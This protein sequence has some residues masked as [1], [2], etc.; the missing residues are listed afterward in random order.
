MVCANSGPPNRVSRGQPTDPCKFRAASLNIGSLKRKE[1]EVVETLTRRRIDICSIQEHRI[2]GGTEAN[3]ARVIAGKDSKYKLYW[4]SCQRGTGGV[5]ILL[6]E[7]WI[8]K[9]T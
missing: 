9:E 7:K 8:D 2:A 5:G 6:A 4:S 1:A 3:Q